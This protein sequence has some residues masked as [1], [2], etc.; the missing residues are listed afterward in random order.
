MADVYGLNYPIKSLAV[1][2]PFV[3]NT[4]KVCYKLGTSLA[5]FCI[6]AKDE[7]KGKVIDF[8]TLSLSDGGKN[9][10]DEIAELR[11]AEYSKFGVN[12]DTS[13]NIKRRLLFFDYLMNIS[14]CYVEVPKWV[15][16]EGNATQTYDKFLVTRNPKLMAE[17]IGS[18]NIAEMNAK[19]VPKIQIKQGELFENTIRFVKLNRSGKG[20]SITVP[21]N[22]VKVEHMTCIPIYMVYAF[23]EG[24]KPHLNNKIL[25]FDYLKDNNTVRS[26]TS[27]LNEEI[28][29]KFYT[30]NFYINS[31]LQSSDINGTKVGGM[32]LP[33][34]FE[35]GYMRIPELGSS[36]YDT[37]VRALNYTRIISIKE[38]AE[39]DVDTT[40]INVDLN[41]V[42][43][44]FF[45][46]LDY[47]MVHNTQAIPELYKSL[48]KE[49]L[50]HT[51]TALIVED[52]K[53]YII[54]NI[55][56]LSTSYKRDLH[57]FM[58]GNPEWFPTYTGKPVN[59]TVSSSTNFG[60]EAL[61]G[62]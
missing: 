53:N 31:M 21:R 20:N 24:V 57:R 28:I 38:V 55:T 45:N 1:A 13:D 61:E 8:A 3:E 50:K 18:E 43:D 51:E 36:V 41:S 17:W 19:Y 47:L 48:T 30:D 58:V 6:F 26:L 37:G 59:T 62:W 2:N 16:K 29:K 46:N 23:L 4:N 27:T 15:T 49:D 52:I 7:Q 44:N 12:I 56:Y 34:K 54:K 60:I 9:I 32:T 11:K 14:I 33:S 25:R 5:P 22:S 35:R 42:Q 40:F 39:S 10:V